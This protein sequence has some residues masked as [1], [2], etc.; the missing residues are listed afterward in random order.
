MNEHP[1]NPQPEVD[2]PAPPEP[3]APPWKPSPPQVLRYRDDKSLAEA[4]A[5]RFLDSAT[6][7]V[8][9]EGRFIVAL[10]GGEAPLLLYRRLAESPYRE[11]VPWKKTFVVFAG[12]PCVPPDD[13]ES[14]HLAIKEILLDPVG[15][16]GHQVL[17][18]K[19]E[20]KPEEAARRYDVRL[21]DLFLTRTRRGFDLVV[22]GIG[23]D[24][25]V[26]ALFP[27]TGALQEQE[28]WVAANRI[29]ESDTWWLTLTMKALNAS[30]R[31]IFLATGEEKARVVAEAFGGLDHPE[32]H[33]CERV[34]PPHARREVLVDPL[35]ASLLP[36]PEE[37]GE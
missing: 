21:G 3:S 5:R 1:E 11:K 12:E 36:R 34:A 17:R 9:K 10:A 20:Q 8:E 22:L 14:H 4:A 32:P 18:M 23:A 25:G 2:S 6:R 35:A 33:P 13:P 30:R 28:R 27:G 37:A 29:Q 24:G 15:V 31:V 16:T 19:G 26:A 7:A